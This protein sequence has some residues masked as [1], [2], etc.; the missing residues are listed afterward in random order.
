MVHPS[1]TGI[2]A[3]L[4][5]LDIITTNKPGL[6]GGPRGLAEAGFPS[7][8]YEASYEVHN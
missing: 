4:L 5:S 1:P 7:P 6:N 2:L 3:K 8:S